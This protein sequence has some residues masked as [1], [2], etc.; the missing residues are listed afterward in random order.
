MGILATANE[1]DHQLLLK[2]LL[3]SEPA[4]VKVACWLTQKGYP[5]FLEPLP[6]GWRESTYENRMVFT[7]SGD[8]MVGFRVEVKQRSFHFTCREDWPYPGGMIVSARHSFDNAKPKPYAFVHLN[9]AGTHCAMV[10]ASS[11]SCWKVARHKDSRYANVEQENYV[12]PLDRVVF[13]EF[14]L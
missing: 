8:L 3:Q 14:S 12:V 11:A 7:D 9:G 10:R 6:L 2:H 4:R 5:V 13:A 1:A